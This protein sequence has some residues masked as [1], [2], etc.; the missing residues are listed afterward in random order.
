MSPVRAVILDVDGTLVLSNDEHARAFVDAAAEMGVEAD[1]GEIRRMIG[2]GG[3]K[4]IP[5]AFGFEKES[6]QGERLDG[7]KGEISRAR[8]LPGLRPTPG[9]RALCERLREQG[10]ELVVAT[11]A[12]EEDLE[13][14]LERA[15]VRDLIEDS[16]S[17]GDVEESKPEPDVVEAALAQA[18]REAG[19]VV[20][21]GDTPYDVE[22]ATR[23]GVR[24]VAVR[25][26]GWDEAD[27]RGAAA[28]YDHPQDLLEH[29]EE[30]PLGRGR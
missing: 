25:C 28:V 19:E 6:P 18:G 29:L 11:S 30:S 22:A 8:Y 7:R 2:M 9:A 15:G 16:T 5:R 4:L 3:D 27:L 12:S 10:I 1:Y 13:G 14:L 20:M 21:I 26:G 24:I 23:A 17:A